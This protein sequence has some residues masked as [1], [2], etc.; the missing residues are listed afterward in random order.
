MLLL[1]RYSLINMSQKI[2][3]DIVFG[4]AVIPASQIFLMRKNVFAIIRNPPLSK[5]HV[6]VCSRRQMAKFQDLT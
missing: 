2:T 6:L 3:G 5:G 4:E 1:L